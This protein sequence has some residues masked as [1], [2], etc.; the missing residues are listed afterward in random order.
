[1]TSQVREKLILNGNEISMTFCP[2]L[3]DNPDLIEAMSREEAELSVKDIK[4]GRTVF[5]TACWRGYI[6]TWEIKDGNLYLN[7]IIGRYRMKTDTPI[8]AD[9]FTGVLRVPE[10]EILEYIHMGY[11]TVFE[12]ELHIKIEKGKVVEEHE[13]DNRNKEIDAD[14][15]A[16]ANLPGRENK[17]DGDEY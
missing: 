7:D 15:L 9:W 11:A 1:M 14:K 16:M 17:F 6:G 10:G 12:K 4:Y 3:P 2:P 5:S 13:I 8:F